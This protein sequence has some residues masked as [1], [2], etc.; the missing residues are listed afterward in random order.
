MNTDD[1]YNANKNNVPANN[2]NKKDTPNGHTYR[3]LGASGLV[4]DE[5]GNIYGV[6]EIDEWREPE[7]PEMKR[8]LEEFNKRIAKN[9]FISQLDDKTNPAYWAYYYDPRYCGPSMEAYCNKM[10]AKSRREQGHQQRPVSRDNCPPVNDV[11][12]SVLQ[13]TTAQ[14]QPKPKP[15]PKTTFSS[16]PKPKATFSSDSK[17]ETKTPDPAFQAAMQKA[18]EEQKAVILEGLYPLWKQMKGGPVFAG[19]LNSKKEVVISDKEYSMIGPFRNGLAV[20][21]SRK[22]K[23]FGF[24]DRHGNEV[25]PCC[26][27]S[28]GPFNEYMAAVVDEHRRCGYVDVT[29][30]LVVQCL[31]DEGWPFQNGFAR[32]QGGNQKIGMIDQS[33]RL[34]IP[35]IWKGMGDFSEGLA[36]VQD[37]NGKCGYIDKTGKVV[38]PCRWKQ[39][40]TFCEGRAV[41]QD[42]NKKLGFID[43]AGELV[44]PCIWKRVNYFNKGLA[45]VAKS[46][47]FLFKFKWVYI[48][49]QGNIVKQ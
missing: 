17:S 10:A 45:K 31:W 28:V 15:A 11:V 19:I 8:R 48:D 37:D 4:E 34:V 47:R 35:C 18:D 20:A 38:I 40:W 33:G 7:D 29:G 39:V 5:E 26:W 41:V 49:P 46:R 36:G 44:I 3:S 9:S 25:V 42:F 2:G 30:R 14:K 23:K 22:T 1:T 32:V 21:H 13:A 27:R 43:K 16:G 24:I 6:D 12:D